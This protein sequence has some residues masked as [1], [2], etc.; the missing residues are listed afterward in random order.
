MSHDPWETEEWAWDE[1][2]MP[3]ASVHTGVPMQDASLA[4]KLGEPKIGE[5]RKRHVSNNAFASKHTNWSQECQ[6]Q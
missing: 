5:K 4:Q 6:P 3:A 1:V 2:A